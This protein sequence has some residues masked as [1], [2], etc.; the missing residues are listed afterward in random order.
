MPLL[1]AIWGALVASTGNFTIV[2]LIAFAATGPAAG[3]LLGGPD[4]GNRTALALA[5]ATRHPGVAIAVLHAVAPSDRSVAPDVLLYLLV[6]AVV[7]APYVALRKRALVRAG[8][9]IHA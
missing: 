6:A 7:S 4:P 3:H 2:A 9:S 1:W 5:T 8:R